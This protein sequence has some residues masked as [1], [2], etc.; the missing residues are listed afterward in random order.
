MHLPTV[1][2]RRSAPTLFALVAVAAL[3]GSL[4]VSVTL[5]SATPP[6]GLHCPDGW[7]AK[8]ESGADDNDFVP[9]AGTDI[10]VKAGST[11][12]NDSESGN[13]GIVTADG[14][15]SLCDYLAA[16]GIVGGDEQC[17]NVSYWVVYGESSGSASASASQSEEESASASASQSEEESAS[18]SASQSEEESASASASQSEEESA[19]ASASQS[20]E[21]SVE[22]GTGTPEQS[23]QGGTGSPAASMGNGATS[24]AGSTSAIPAIAFGIL[25]LLSLGG[26]A[27]VNLATVRRRR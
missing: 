10:C 24:A 14:E 9:A 5:V 22:G 2:R 16:A 26:M 1:E 20:A 11:V 7:S 19:S 3:V 18:A 12:S 21:Q 25:A 6:P 8:D 13:T 4:F 17:R 15:M 23:V 27:A